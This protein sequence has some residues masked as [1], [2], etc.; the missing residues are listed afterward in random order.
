MYNIEWNDTI[1]IGVPSIDEDHRRLVG[2]LNDLFAAC[3]AA[4][5]PA[6]I[7]KIMDELVD[8]TKY[9]FE[10]EE[11]LLADVHYDNLDA[12]KAEHRTMVTQ[13]EKYQ[14][15]LQ[16]SATHDLSND[17]LKFLSHWLTD[18]IQAEDR[19]FGPLLRAENLG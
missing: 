2:L 7:R 12:H 3:F 13:V 16:K 11:K 18:H 19:E 9:H 14:K 17:T 15:D 10:R 8:Y 1:A 5:G 4:Q 6:M